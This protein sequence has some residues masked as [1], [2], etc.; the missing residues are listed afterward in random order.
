MFSKQLLHFTFQSQRELRLIFHGCSSRAAT[1][2]APTQIGVA[3]VGHGVYLLLCGT[4]AFRALVVGNLK[5]DMRVTV[6]FG[7]PTWTED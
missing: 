2:R 5:R 7:A 6:G 3:R 4:D 1:L